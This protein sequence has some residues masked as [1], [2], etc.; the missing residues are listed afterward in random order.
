MDYWYVWLMAMIRTHSVKNGE[1]ICIE[2][3][4]ILMNLPLLPP[5]AVFTYFK[6]LKMLR[7][8]LTSPWIIKW[9]SSEQ[10]IL[11]AMAYSIGA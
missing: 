8:C 10:I 5:F 6:Y 11:T 2:Q 4:K 3:S 7:A 1:I 9:R